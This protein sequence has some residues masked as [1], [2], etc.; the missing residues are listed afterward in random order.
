MGL[1]D[2]KSN[3]VQQ[4]KAKRVVDVESFVNGAELYAKGI[5]EREIPVSTCQQP[6][7]VCSDVDRN[8]Q[9]KPS[10]FT[11]NAITRQRLI[12][13]SEELNVSKSKLIRIAVQNLD[14]MSSLEKHLLKSV[15]IED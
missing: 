11:L 14:N 13:N 3:Y 7:M 8:K 9:F 6:V 4:S 1:L 15:Y 5:P 2:L 12:N 10:T